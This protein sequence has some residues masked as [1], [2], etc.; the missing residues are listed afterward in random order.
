MADEGI[1]P[2]MLAP[3]YQSPG[4]KGQVRMTTQLLFLSQEHCHFHI[5]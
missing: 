1:F 3:Y 5:L 4:G 2:E